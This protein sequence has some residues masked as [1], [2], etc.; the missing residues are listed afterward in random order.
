VGLILAAAAVRSVG[1]LDSMFEGVADATRP[2]RDEAA[3]D[4]A[5]VLNEIP[6]KM[7]ATVGSELK[8]SRRTWRHCSTTRSSRTSWAVWQR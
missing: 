6:A 3:V 4:G 2:V 8:G 5:Q 1:D 7:G